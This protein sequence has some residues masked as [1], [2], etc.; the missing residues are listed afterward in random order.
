MTGKTVSN[1]SKK[2]AKAGAAPK[3]AK[4]EILE[5]VSVVVQA[6]LIAL[7]FRSF[8]FQPFNIP[9]ASMQHNLLIGD[10][11][12]ASKF[13]YGYSKYSF[14]LDI[15]PIKGRLF[16]REPTRGD[17]IIFRPIPHENEN[18]IKRLI[19]LPGDT[20][21]MREGILYLN[22]TALPRT[23]TGTRMDTDSHGS[24]IEVTLW[25]ETMPNGVSYE[26]Q[27][28]SDSSPL[29]NTGKYL[30]PAGHYFF[31]GDNRD[32]S[33]DSRVL[34]QVGYVPFSNLVGKAQFRFFSVD[35][36]NGAR[37]WM[38]WRWTKDVRWSRIFE[39][40]YQ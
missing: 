11:L 9:T 16:G 26:V 40:V 28:I 29:D 4:S 17:I 34:N 1:S 24:T 18:Y 14:P 8:L 35:Y 37:P 36:A 12:L 20:I 6:L 22:G 33:G 21:Q 31:M 32:R 30:V 39:S 25:R 13:S 10:Y 7:V 15:A 5:L 23:R 38:I 3:S 27:E 2:P 19:G